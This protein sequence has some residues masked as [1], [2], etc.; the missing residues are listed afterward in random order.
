VAGSLVALGWEASLL[1][2]A[3]INAAAFA[4]GALISG[5]VY[6]LVELR[7][8]RNHRRLRHRKAESLATLDKLIYAAEELPDLLEDLPPVTTYRLKDEASLLAKIDRKNAAE[9][10]KRG[11]SIE[12]LREQGED[13]KITDIN[14]ALG[15]RYVV[16]P[17]RVADVVDRVIA[18][19]HPA[20]IDYKNA[21]ERLN[22]GKYRGFRMNYK[23]IHI[24]VDL[25]G[26]GARKDVNLMAEVQVRTPIQNLF[27]NWF[28]DIMY[29]EK[30]QE[31]SETA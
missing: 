14:D 6:G 12:Q 20:G 16:A 10:V 4:G 7:V 27:A 5:L 30:P 15:I 17:W 22:R 9:S 8:L 2:F 31:C 21:T 28:H 3:W 19:T 29:K 24:D 11:I 23:S 26:V 13:Y 25:W 18:V 1:A